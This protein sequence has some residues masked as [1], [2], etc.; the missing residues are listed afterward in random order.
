MHIISL[1]RLREFWE[2]HPAAERPLRAWYV[3]VDQ[4][5]WQNFAQVKSD[6][7]TA[8]QVKRLTV[9]NISGNNYRLIARI[10]YQLQKIYVRTVLTH[11]EYDD[12]QW[13]KD[14]WYE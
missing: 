7:P 12:D 14:E 11:G 1:R 9:F 4:A 13:K 5:H 10:E 6:F 8:D 2:N 3:R